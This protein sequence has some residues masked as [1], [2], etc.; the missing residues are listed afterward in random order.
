MPE[1]YRNNDGNITMF[2]LYSD[3]VLASSDMFSLW[4]RFLFLVL[5][6]LIIYVRTSIV[7]S[8]RDRKC[9]EAQACLVYFFTVIRLCKFSYIPVYLTGSGGVHW[10]HD[11]D[12]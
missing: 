1:S 10:V 8:S 12:L 6:I 7:I 5:I 9:G 3:S 4:L 2:S 11:N